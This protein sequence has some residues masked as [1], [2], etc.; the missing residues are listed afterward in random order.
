MAKKVN[1]CFGRKS[2]ATEKGNDLSQRICLWCVKRKTKL[3]SISA[4]G[5]NLCRDSEKQM[6]HWGVSF[7]Y[8]LKTPQQ[9]TISPIMF[10]LRKWIEHW[11]VRQK[12]WNNNTMASPD[13]AVQ[14]F[15]RINNDLWPINSKFQYELI[16]QLKQVCKMRIWNQS[17]LR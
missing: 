3:K 5:G 12:R 17:K 15:P 14:T 13:C 6:N 1:N 16:L 10:Q 8:K 7:V 4:H 9:P 2:G 11:T